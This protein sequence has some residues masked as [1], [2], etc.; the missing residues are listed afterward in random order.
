MTK[1]ITRRR[2]G[3]FALAFLASVGLGTIGRADLIA[4][5][6]GGNYVSSAQNYADHNPLN[7]SGGN[8]YGD[9][10]GP[11]PDGGGG[12]IA[13]RAYRSTPFS[14]PS[15]YSGTSDTFW[16]GGSVTSPTLP[17]NDGFNDL[18]VLNQGPN[19]SLHFHVDTGTH[20]HTFHQLIYWD[21]ANFLNGLYAYPNLKLGTGQFVIRT[22]QVAGHHTDQD[23]RWVVRNGSQFYVSQATVQ[24]TNNATITVP[25]SS[26]TNWG[27]YNPTLAGGSPTAADLLS[28]DFNEAGAFNPQTF[29]NVTGLGFYIEHEN[30]TGPTH[31]HIEGFSATSVPEPSSALL[32][33]MSLMGI[34]L[35][36]GQRHLRANGSPCLGSTGSGIW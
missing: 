32:S 33:L 25:Y 12:S 14:P 4:V 7:T 1:S 3:T 13:G 29:L 26:L 34:A 5:E 2:K 23:L 6:W 10:D 30:A 22:S 27:L 17:S 21:K 35:R 24:L 31:V 16:G 15:G 19:D 11:F 28:L 36:R 8:Q 20:V 18:E 9:P